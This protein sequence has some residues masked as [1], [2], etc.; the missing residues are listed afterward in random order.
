MMIEECIQYIQSTYIYI[1]ENRF[2]LYMEVI[3]IEK[4]G[5]KSY[6]YTIRKDNIHFKQRQ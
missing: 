1:Y 5:E 6:I 2:L 3:S 4:I